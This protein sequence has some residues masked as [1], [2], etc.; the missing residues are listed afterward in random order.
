MCDFLAKE[1]DCEKCAYSQPFQDGC[2]YY[3]MQLRCMKNGSIVTYTRN[4]EKPCKLP[5]GK[6]YKAEYVVVSDN[7]KK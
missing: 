7:V 2:D 3:D 1:T 6:Y 5:E 4:D